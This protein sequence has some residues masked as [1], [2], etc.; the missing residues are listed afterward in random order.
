MTLYEFN[1]LPQ[2]EQYSIL[3]KVGEFLTNRSEEN[4]TYALYQVT[5]FYVELEYHQD[6]NKLLKM[7][8]FSS[9]TPLEPYLQQIPLPTI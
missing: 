7:K 2:P 8:T 3:W 9:T 4:V 1:L 6:E 5:G